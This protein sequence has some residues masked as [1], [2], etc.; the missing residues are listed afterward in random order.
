MVNS[1]GFHRVGRKK[2]VV[3]LSANPTNDVDLVQYL[4]CRAPVEKCTGE[5]PDCHLN[6]K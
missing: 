4:L 6:V 3:E 5:L 1:M 2:F